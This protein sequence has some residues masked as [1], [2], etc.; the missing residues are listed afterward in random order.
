MSDL[1]LNKEQVEFLREYVQN[2]KELLDAVHCYETEEFRKAA[3]AQAILNGAS[4]EQAQSEYE[5]EDV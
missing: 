5:D 4:L 1:V 3:V 2:V